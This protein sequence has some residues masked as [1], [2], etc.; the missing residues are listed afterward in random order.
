MCRSHDEGA[1][2]VRSKFMVWQHRDMSE[3]QVVLLAG[4]GGALI[5]ALAALGSQGLAIWHQ[6]RGERRREG[7]DLVSRFWAA[8][9]R[10]WTA[11][12]SLEYTIVDLQASRQAGHGDRL[13]ELD[14]RRLAEIAERKAA[15][16]EARFLL[17]QMRLLS[18][19]LA[20]P[21]Q[22]LVEASSQFDHEHREALREFRETALEAFESAAIRSLS[23]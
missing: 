15:T 22:K 16:T 13:D 21:A 4:L 19:S 23:K 7:V 10:L 9:D 2:P 18:P 6:S 8:A 1:L 20:D 3:T 14:D 5:G 17:A 11:V 12:N